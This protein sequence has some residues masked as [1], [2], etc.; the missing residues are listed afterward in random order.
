[1]ASNSTKENN[2]NA[3]NILG[4]KEGSNEFAGGNLSLQG[5]IFDVSSKEAIHQFAKTVKAIA[6]C[7]SQE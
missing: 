1:M 2:K 6:N 7:F 3:G 4:V 5:K